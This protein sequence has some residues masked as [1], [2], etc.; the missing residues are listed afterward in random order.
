MFAQTTQTIAAEKSKKEREEYFCNGK[1][2]DI[3]NN[4]SLNCGSKTFML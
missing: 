2:N 1:K 3:I 4:G